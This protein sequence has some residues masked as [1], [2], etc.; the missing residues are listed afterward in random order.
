MLKSLILWQ[1]KGAFMKTEK[2]IR[3]NVIISV[4]EKM[5][6]AAKTAPKGKGADTIEAA[7]I[8]GDEIKAVSDLLL[9]MQKD[10]RAP[11]FFARDAANILHSSAVVLI[12]TRIKAL[13]ISPCGNCG[14]ADCAEKGRHPD[15]PCAFNTT[16][17]GIA[18]GSAVS[19]AADNRIDNRVM[20][21]VGYAAKEM[22]LFPDDVKIIYGIP[23]SSGSKSPFF[24]RG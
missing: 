23:L 8:T 5:L 1:Y 6:V 22:G 9:A 2:D 17:L 3:D 21:T 13:G 18:V 19:I 7:V 14:F 11:E 20:F 4:A 16:D 10:G 12:G 24:D 15:I